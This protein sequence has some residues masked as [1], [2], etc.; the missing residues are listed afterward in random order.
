MHAV[1]LFTEVAMATALEVQRPPTTT[2]TK[3]VTIV[4][5]PGKHSCERLEVTLRPPPCTINSLISVSFH[6]SH[7]IYDVHVDH[8]RE[9]PL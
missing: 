4:F 9:V 2:G 5:S 8:R 1:A 3:I 7:T 6:I